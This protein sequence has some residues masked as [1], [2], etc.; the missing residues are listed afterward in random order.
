MKPIAITSSIRKK[1]LVALLVGGVSAPSAY[2]AVDLTV[3][4]EGVVL[5]VYRDSA[6]YPTECIGRLNKTAKVGESRSLEECIN[7]FVED[8]KKHQA[9]LDRVVKV[10]YRSEWQR[11][12]F[13]D[14]TFNKGIGAV[15]SSTLLRLMNQGKHD[16]ACEQLSRWVYAR[17]GKTGVMEVLRGLVIRATAQYKYCMGDIPYDKKQDYEKLLREIEKDTL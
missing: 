7:K 2:V 11:G 10:E 13:T 14:F 17:N 9:Q 16:L 15:Q 1:I 5:G 12:A 8:W 3:P 4:S 6:G